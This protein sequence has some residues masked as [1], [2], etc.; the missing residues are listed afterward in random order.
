MNTVRQVLDDL[1][2]GIITLD[3]AAEDFRVRPAP[4]KRQPTTAQF[5][6]VADDVPDRD[7]WGAL[8]SD[9]RLTTAQY[10][11]LIKAAAAGR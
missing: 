6:G 10:Q 8:D 3:Q 4:G 9:I 7:G 1:H 5:W 11:I 2:A